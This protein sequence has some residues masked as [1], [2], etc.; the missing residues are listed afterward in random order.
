MTYQGTDETRQKKIENF[1][2]QNP[3]DMRLAMKQNQKIQNFLVQ[4]PK[5]M[6]LM[7]QNQKLQNF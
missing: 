5:D 4:N 6:K 3:S 2:V 1:L 7:K